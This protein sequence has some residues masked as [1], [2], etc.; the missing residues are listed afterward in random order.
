MIRRY[1]TLCLLLTAT[2]FITQFSNS[3][4]AGTVA[5]SLQAEARRAAEIRN[6]PLLQRP[7]RP[8]HF[9]GNTIR[10]NYANRMTSGR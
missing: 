3:A 6:M 1:L 7:N 8:G 10:R 9:I 2:L 4:A 5:N